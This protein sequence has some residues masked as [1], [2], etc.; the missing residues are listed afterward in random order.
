[1][2]GHFVRW[3]NVRE[4]IEFNMHVKATGVA[5]FDMQNLK[6]ERRE[7]T[8]S[9]RHTNIINGYFSSVVCLS[10]TFQHKVLSVA[11]GIPIKWLNE[12]RNVIEA[13][14]SRKGQIVTRT[15]RKREF[16]NEQKKSC[17][18]YLFIEEDPKTSRPKPIDQIYWY[19]MG[20]AYFHFHQ[21]SVVLSQPH[22]ICLSKSLMTM[23][24]HP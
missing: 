20:D 21:R 13:Q 11:S 19:V 17:S 1:M 14:F 7:R 4:C 9:C 23:C 6:M 2:P 18:K 10:A 22:R 5:L 12:K 8:T 16:S 3:C 15:Y 24:N